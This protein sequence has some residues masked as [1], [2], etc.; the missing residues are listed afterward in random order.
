MKEYPS[1][2]GSKKA[3]LGKYCI[4]F[5]KYDGSNLRWEWSP[6]KG[7][8]KFGT[9]TQLFDASNPLYSKAILIFMDTM[10]DEIVRR[11]K[12]Y[13]REVQRIT[14]Y[15]E[16]FGPHSFAGQHDLADTM[17]LRLFDAFLFQ[18][19]F[20]PPR[21]FVQ[22]FVGLPWAAEVVYDGVL[23]QQFIADVRQG[24]YPVVEGVVAKGDD[25]MV[26]IKTDAYFAKLNEVYGTAYRQYWE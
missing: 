16:F 25:F 21:A 13:R 4:A 22:T 24:K 2:D 26:K 15:T 14:A 19:G 3:P 8:T 11:V 7:W 12:G 17:E 18:K 10:A 1:I 9:R 5:V 20:I 6:K 23:N